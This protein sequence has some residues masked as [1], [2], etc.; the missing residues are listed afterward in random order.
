MTKFGEYE[1]EKWIER[2][3]NTFVLLLPHSSLEYTVADDLE[4]R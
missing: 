4:G 3:L 2:W 1:E